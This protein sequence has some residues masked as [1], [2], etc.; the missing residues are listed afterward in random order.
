MSDGYQP[1]INMDALLMG[2]TGMD[3]AKAGMLKGYTQQQV[4]RQAKPAATEGNKDAARKNP[5]IR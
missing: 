2:Y 4:E 3:P 5:Y 1:K